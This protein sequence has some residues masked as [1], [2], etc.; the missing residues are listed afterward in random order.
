MIKYFNRIEFWILIFFLIR[1]IG[2]TN[3][4]LEIGHNWRQA[5]GLMV[6]RNYLEV[7][8]NI[9]YPRVDDN[10][11]NTGIIGMEFPSLNY[12]YF[13]VSK[14]FGYSHWY[15]RLINLI[16]SSIGLFFYYKLVCLLGFKER[17]A[18]FSTIF[19][20]A[21]AWFT[22]SRKMMPDTYCISIMFM[23]LYYGL[24]FLSEKRFYQLLLYIFLS[25]LAILS[26]IPAGIYFIVLLPLM[27]TNGF[28]LKQR[29]VLLFYTIIPLTLTYIWY[30]VWNPKLSRDF[31]NWYNYGKPI[32][33]GFIEISE[34]LGKTLD[35]FYFDAFS[36]YIIFLLF[37]AGMFI[38]F[39]RTDRRMI[40]GFLL[41]FIVFVVYI[42]KSGFY[43]YYHN[44]YIIP[45][46]P[47]MALVAGYALSF[48]QK[49]WILLA[50][51]IL[52]VGEGIANQ[53]HD[54]FNKSSER[55]KLELEQIMDKISD[56]EDLV[57][58]NGNGNPQMM[59]LAHRKGWNCS[60]EQISDE[61]FLKGVIER[62]CKFIIINKHYYAN[63][64]NLSLPFP[65]VFESDDFV[66]FATKTYL[67]DL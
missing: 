23:G 46:V 37:L 21:S 9:L 60:D 13:L 63:I 1:L 15:G 19:L 25:S 5:T 36:S 8:A 12:L 65:V 41:P 38:M 24:R 56:K 59:Y 4:P 57:T 17:I 26:K 10:N 45:F 7:D 27:L 35:N 29:A 22:F 6:T 52:G 3:P 67:K 42:F 39:I 33:T 32:K 61:S 30:F 11:G 16:I 44:Y 48:I 40:I 55:Y 14:I 54:F 53:Q 47:V 2:I 50:L 31:G 43:F 18:F 64:Q 28:G 34:N 58:I 51:L 49:K 62:N 20:S 66:I